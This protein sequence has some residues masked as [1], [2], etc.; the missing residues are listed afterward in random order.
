MYKGCW[1]CKNF[2]D[3]GTCAAFPARIP[4]SIVSGQLEHTMVL[5]GQAGETVY[6]ELPS[7]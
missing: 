7:G 1:F 3:D 4:L 6:E 5:K 2:R